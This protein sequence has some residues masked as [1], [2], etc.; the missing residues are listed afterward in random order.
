MHHDKYIHDLTR[1][2]GKVQSQEKVHNG[3][4]F[5]QVTK[6]MYGIPQA[7]LIEHNTVVK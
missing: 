7:G 6:G 3:Y 1:I 4:I 2:R 5:S